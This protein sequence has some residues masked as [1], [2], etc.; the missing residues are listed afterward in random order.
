MPRLISQQS[1]GQTIPRRP[2]T[3]DRQKQQRDSNLRR[4]DGTE[5]PRRLKKRVDGQAAKKR[6]FEAALEIVEEKRVGNKTQYLVR[7]A[8]QSLHYCDAVSP[9]LLRMYRTKKGQHAQ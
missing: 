3:A 4:A 5:R 1:N 6:R 2:E 8:D 9:L 7:F